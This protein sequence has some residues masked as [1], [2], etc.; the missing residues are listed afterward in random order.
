MEEQWWK[1]PDQKLA[2]M[3]KNNSRMDEAE[4][5]KGESRDEA[6]D[7]TGMYRLL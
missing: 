4:W 1:G 2:G 5:E 6:R 7:F 3:F